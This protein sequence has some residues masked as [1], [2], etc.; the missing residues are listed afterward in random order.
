M[1]DGITKVYSAPAASGARRRQQERRSAQPFHLP[2]DGEEEDGGDQRQ[3]IL[4]PK[5]RRSLED[6]IG[7]KPLAEEAGQSL[8]VRA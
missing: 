6:R 1:T 2:F 5:P 4:H 8:D 7:T 3:I